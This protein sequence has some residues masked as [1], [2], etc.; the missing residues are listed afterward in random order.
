MSDTFDMLCSD[1]LRKYVTQVFESDWAVAMPFTANQQYSADDMQVITD[2]SAV[3]VIIPPRKDIDTYVTPLQTIQVCNTH[4]NMFFYNL[5][6]DVII[7]ECRR[8]SG[9]CIA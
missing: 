3:E 6:A 9:V 5:V 2:R 8:G 1:P 7:I 4:M